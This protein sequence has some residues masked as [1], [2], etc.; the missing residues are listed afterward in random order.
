MS[1]PKK[2]QLVHFLLIALAL[3]AWIG[4]GGHDA[5]H[6]AAEDLA[7]DIHDTAEDMMHVDEAGE[8]RVFFLEPQDGATVGTTVNLEFG[9][10]NFIIEPVGDGMVHEGHGHFHIGLDT[11]C[12]PAGE[13]I[14]TA[15]P[16]I[17][18]GDGSSVIEYSLPPGE[19]T[20]TLQIGDGEHRTLPDP[21]LCTTITVNAQDA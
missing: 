7:D 6:D 5:V 1:H 12:L 2:R 18:F 9:S 10:E 21:G 8:P 15:D 20:L 3:V 14:P 16:W 13:V 11:E 19:H 17:H 4:C